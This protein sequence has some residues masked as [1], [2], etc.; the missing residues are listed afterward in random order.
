MTVAIL[1]SGTTITQAYGGNTLSRGDRNTA[2][3]SATR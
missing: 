2:V 1:W 3:H